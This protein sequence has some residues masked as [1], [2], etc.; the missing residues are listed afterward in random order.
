[1][2]ISDKQI[3][4][5]NSKMRWIAFKSGVRFIIIVLILI[6]IALTIAIL[7]QTG[8]ILPK[9]GNRSDIYKR[10]LNPEKLVTF[11][12]KI[13]E[14]FKHLRKSMGNRAEFNYALNKSKKI[15]NFKHQ[16]SVNVIKTGIRA[17]FYVNWD[18]QSF[19]SLREHI[20]SMNMVFP[21]WLFI[22]DSSNNLSLDIDT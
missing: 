4:Q 8:T 10:I 17:G 20:N 2:E 5:G 13:N 16:N 18:L 9:L 11:K 19:Y 22:P 21:E 3:F 7:S 1:M 14:D 15:I 6:A 12:T